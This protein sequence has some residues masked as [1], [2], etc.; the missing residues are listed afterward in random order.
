M[1]Q[2]RV[3]I[4]A[5]VLIVLGTCFLGH[6]FGFKAHQIIAQM[7]VFTLPPEVIPFYKSHWEELKQ[8]SIQPDIRRYVW[9]EEKPRHYIDL[10]HYSRS[11][12]DTLQKSWEDVLKSIPEDTLLEY[13]IL[14]Y[15]LALTKFNLTQAMASKDGSS[16]IRLSGDLAHYASDASVPLHTTENYNGQLTGQKG[17]H[18]LWESRIPELEAENYMYWQKPAN[19]ISNIREAIWATILHSH[20][21][22]D[23]VLLLEDKLS[24]NSPQDM[25]YS[26]K[27]VGKKTNR[28]YSNE[29]VAAYSAQLNGMVERQM[30]AA[31]KFTGD[32]WFTC[33]VDAGQPDLSDI[34]FT[35]EPPLLDSTKVNDPRSTLHHK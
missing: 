14:P 21:L 27:E 16:I 19:Y 24:K 3:S 22:V 17:I 20:S 13:G 31:I 15:A 30:Q 26:F 29:Y 18:A 33:W 25:K 35:S 32:L 2:K 6:S 5:C 9:E 1:L 23:S 4:G 8:A 7:A 12:Q 34:Q 11:Q 28:T 10:D